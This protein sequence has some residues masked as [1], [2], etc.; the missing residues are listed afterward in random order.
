MPY[1]REET[2]HIWLASID[3]VGPITFASLLGIFGTPE[4]VFL[5][6][7]KNPGLLDGVPRFGKRTAQLLINSCNE[8]HITKFFANMEK[9]GVM[10]VPRISPQYPRQLLD[11]FAPPLV[12]YCRGRLE[13][14]AH[15]RIVAVIGTR[16][17]T[18]YGRNVA[19]RIARVLGE[20]GVL[21]ISGMA[22]GIDVCAHLGA[23]EGHGDTIAVLGNGVDIAY[24][25]DKAYV[26]EQICRDGLAI[27]EYIPGTQPAPGNFP[28]RNRIIS[29]M[30]RGVVV[31]E[32]GEKSGTNITVNYALE[33]GKDV[34][35]VPGSI[36]SRTSISTNQLIKSGCEVVT[37]EEDVLEY[38]G[39]G[40]R[41]PRRSIAAKVKAAPPVQLSFQERMLAD[42]LEV[43][44]KSFDELYELSQFSM[45][46]LFTLLAELELKG[47]IAQKP[48]RV[49]VLGGSA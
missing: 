5:N 18:P 12:L 41:T 6:A 10:A 37:S 7:P 29:G 34:F 13:L 49:Y 22:K 25:A 11:V 2:Y 28:A 38:Y 23:L 1:T 4:G 30:A 32:A 47:V 36:T 33:Q 9:K 8:E 16:E 14:L 15:E 44:E 46:E 31:V 21:V 20:N 19:G 24:P 27:S 42:A 40:G 3:G 17:P 35:A 43:G 26:Y 39:W 45:P 48:G